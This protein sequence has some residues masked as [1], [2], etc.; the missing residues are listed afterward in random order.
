M[1]SCLIG[2]LI[3]LV[4][5][6]AASGSDKS[7]STSNYTST[8]AKQTLSLGEVGIINYK[9]D[10]NDCTGQTILG[11]TKESQDKITTALVANDEIGLAQL[12]ITREAFMVDNCTKVKVIDT[13]VSLRQVRILEGE[14]VGKSG[15][16]PYE[17]AIK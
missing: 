9:T 7:P 14:Q 5:F 8:P 12:V 4:V 1:F 15:W 6:L 13:A 11:A 3:I 2:V 10:R 17:W 16:L